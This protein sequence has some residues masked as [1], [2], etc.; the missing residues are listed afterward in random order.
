MHR[1]TIAETIQQLR[2]K[3]I[4]SRELTQHYLDR[5]DS[6]AHLNSYISVCAEEALEQA[7][8]SDQRLS[9]D[10]ES[11]GVLEGVPLG[12]KDL[13][14]T[15]GLR[16]TA[17]S[18][19]LHN[20]VPPY[21]S[22]V[23]EKLRKAGAVFLGKTNMDEFAMGS[24]NVTSAFGPV[25]NP[26]RSVSRPEARLVPG[27]S[28][29]G[30]A[31]AV[32]A[33][34]C[35]GSV[36]SDT[37]GS[38]R[39][40]A[41][42]CGIVGIRPTYG[43]CS[44]YGMVAFASLLDQAGPMTKDVRDSAILLREISG[45]DNRDSTSSQRE[46]PDFEAFL[47]R[48]IKGMRVGIPKEYMHES[49]QSEIQQSWQRG[50][51]ILREAGAVIREVSLPYTKYAL[52]TYYIISTAEASSN[53][54]RYDGIRYGFRDENA[55]TLTDMYELTREHGFGDEVKRRIL[56]GT[57]VLSSGHMDAYYMRARNVVNIIKQ[58][59]SDIFHDV[60]V[61]LTPT[62]PSTAFEIGQKEDDPV[63][64]YLNDIF[65]VT[66]NLAGLCAMS[67]PSE[68][69]N[70]GLPIGLQLIAPAFMEERLIMCGSV[71]EKG[72]AFPILQDVSL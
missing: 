33:H 51:E 3:K 52:P 30:S 28:S 1:L 14:V 34:L 9:G 23:T 71:L 13:F 69:D 43:R 54:A 53:L 65:T 29:G 11:C 49:T 39:Q 31:A 48:S 24:A 6:Y 59:F 32:A 12:I 15:K 19:M 40:P 10:V 22:C 20:F 38:I 68:L 72:F 66:V 61:F 36:G 45:F 58:N 21:E 44:R 25:V 41:A 37:G 47:G 4:S 67:V 18:K 62:T 56:L 16:T 70:D 55:R 17:G 57:Y 2:S 42:F 7:Q 8:I 5:I 46:V 27:G 63:K 60:D 26:W 64:M 35:A 50:I